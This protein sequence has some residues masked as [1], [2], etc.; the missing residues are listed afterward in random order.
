[1]TKILLIRHGSTDALGKHLSG[2]KPGV[3]LNERGKK[4]AQ[5]LSQYLRRSS[6]SYIYSSP[7][8]RAME[9]AQF[10]ADIHQLKIIVS[11]EF[12]E[13]NYGA[14]TNAQFTD[15]SKEENFQR[16]NDFRSIT[17]IPSGELMPEAQ[18]RIIKGIEKLCL[19]HP[20]DTVAVISHA[21]L[22]KS[23]IAYYAGIHLDMFHRL[24]ISPASVSMIEIKE[25]V[26]RILF[27]NYPGAEELMQ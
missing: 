27:I 16:F 10:I 15:L 11:E 22:I 12:S 18:L 14:W 4:E 9:T 8:E 19:K 24:E 21:D 1:M 13:L 6:L 20:D 17:R 26:I 23:A 5:E 2:R 25:R 3:H 7:L